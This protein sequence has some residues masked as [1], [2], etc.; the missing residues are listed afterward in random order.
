MMYDS[1]EF[2]KTPLLLRLCGLEMLEVRFTNT[3][4][5]HNFK[6]KRLFIRRKQ[7]KLHLHEKIAAWR[8]QGDDHK[9]SPMVL[10]ERID[11]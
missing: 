4:N 7:E 2:V 3:D 1:V 8:V 6:G 5:P 10:W 11:K 9:K